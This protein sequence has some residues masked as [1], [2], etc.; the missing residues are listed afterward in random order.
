MAKSDIGILFDV[1]GSMQSPFNSLSHNSSTK[2]ADEILNVIDRIC[3][4]G[5]RLKNEQIRVFSILF[6]GRN[7]KFY[8]FC[9]LIEIANNK[10]RHTL[11]S[12]QYSKAS[13]KGYGK[14]FTEVLS[15]HGRNSLYLDNFLYCE[16]GP[17]ERLCE[18]G[19]YLLED[20]PELRHDIYEKLPDNCKGW[21]RDKGIGVAS[22]FGIA[23]NE[24]NTE[25][26]RVID[27][28]YRDCLNTYVSKIIREDSNYRRY[29]G[30][31]LRFIDGNVLINIKNNLQGKICSPDKTD[32]N[33]IDLFKNYIYGDTPLYTALNLA[34]DNF[35]T[36]SNGSY[37]KF[38]FILSDG[39]LTDVDRNSNYIEKIT[40]KAEDLKV[41][42]ISIF[43]T[44][45]KIPKEE[46]LYDNYQSHFTQG[47]KDLFLMSSTLNYENPVIKF[48]IQK[49]WD[50]P[51]SGECKLFI[52]I[53]NS[54]NLNKFIDLM[55]EAVGEL[56]N[57]NNIE[58]AKNPNSL[59]NL[60]S[61][62]MANDYVNS[63]VINKFTPNDQEG[64]TC[65]ANATAASICFASARVLGRP[66]LDFHT[67]LKKIVDKFGSNGGVVPKVLDYFLGEYRL[68]YRKLS[69]EEDARKSVM[70]T[71]PIIT[72]FVLTGKQWGNFSK[73]FRENPKGIL[74]KE[75]L[76]ENNYYP[77][78]KDG[79][80]GVVLT[81]ISKDYLKFLN[82]W[83]TGF[84]D[85]GYF[86]IKNIEVFAPNYWFYDVFW[87]ISDLNNEEITYFNNYMKNLREDI[88]NYVFN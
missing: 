72:G 11:S 32:F 16:S 18:M 74:T 43:L 33:I 4:R 81:H 44:S 60:L 61:S 53:N 52:E 3:T 51:A 67:V 79:G 59:V 73:F 88:N 27:E 26:T 58:I 64:G 54:Q 8:D 40:Q 37:N 38:L 35:K 9:N 49:G 6:G 28:I 57:R 36:Q 87:Y 63:S 76:N 62:T 66:K 46:V 30:N 50:I 23:K 24:I 15:D 17:T 14:R 56:N 1:S 7:E 85:N 31:K 78:E 45:N 82:S 70:L 13:K 71:R 65:Y 77:D 86:K 2:K 80:H 83:G 25:T 12:D 69:K 29:N 68:H 84:G 39:E 21:F 22:F 5:N 42:I 41:T 47:S 55:N 20:D 48:L 34:F 10:F 75:I 19:C